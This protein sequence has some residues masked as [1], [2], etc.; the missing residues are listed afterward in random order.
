MIH[1]LKETYFFIFIFV[2]F[3][4]IMLSVEYSIRYFC[5]YVEHIILINLYIFQIKLDLLNYK[6]EGM[7]KT[8]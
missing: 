6:K 8:T 4:L 3:S 2:N 1:K 7:N 5:I